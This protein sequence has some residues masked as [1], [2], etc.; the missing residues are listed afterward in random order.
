MKRLPPLAL[1]TFSLV[2]F[3]SASTSAQTPPQTPLQPLPPAPQVPL[4]K[5]EAFAARVGVV[6][7]MGSSTI[8]SVTGRLG[9][10]VSVESKEFLDASTGEREY[11]LAIGVKKPGEGASE[12]FSYIDYDE[13]DSLASGIEY[14]LKVQSSVTKLDRFQADYQTRGAFKITRLSSVNQMLAAI[15]TGE[16]TPPSVLLSLSKLEDLRT[17]IMN[18]KSKLDAIK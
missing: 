6:I 8:G 1:L 5:L 4:R 12:S 16:I 17:L 3:C 18:A 15:S 2:M 11:G 10:S 9:A 14:L 13:I 7:V